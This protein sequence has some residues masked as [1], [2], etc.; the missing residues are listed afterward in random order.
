M[1]AMSKPI[2]YINYTPAGP[3]ELYKTEEQIE[4]HPAY[5]SLSRPTE[6]RARYLGALYFM[7]Q[8]MLDE[9]AGKSW[10]TITDAKAS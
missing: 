8:E 9:A 7:L 6:G 1:L 2:H 4:K 10:F 5:H 3:I